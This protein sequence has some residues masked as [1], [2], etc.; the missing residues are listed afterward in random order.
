VHPAFDKKHNAVCLCARMNTNGGYGNFSV[1]GLP[2]TSNLFTLNSQN[3]NDPFVNVNKSGAANLLLG[4]NEL[5]EVSV[6]ANGYSAQYGQLAG[7]NVNYVTKSGTNALHGNAKYYWDGRILNANDFFNNA[8][9]V[10]RQFVNANQWAA[11]MGGPIKRDKTFF[12]VNNE[13][14]RVVLPTATSP[15]RL[16]SLPFQSATLMNLAST[17]MGAEIPFY[18]Q[19]FK[20]FNSATSASRASAI[21]MG[22]GDLAGPGCGDLSILAPG[23]PCVVGYLASPNAFAHEWQ[24]AMR[25]DQT[26]G[27]NDR[28]YGRFQTDRGVAPTYTDPINPIFSAISSQPEDQGQLAWTHTFGP[29]GKSAYRLGALFQRT[30]WAGQ[31]RCRQRI[32]SV[33]FRHERRLAFELKRYRDIYS[34]RPRVHTVSN[35]R[36]PF[37]YGRQTHSESGAEL[38]PRS[39]KR[40]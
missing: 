20:A 30:V 26:I 17:G 35:R 37:V 21:P 14:L 12:F 22:P 2:G 25:I 33:L 3:D 16:P 32:A 31:S 1:F 4:A 7:A 23:V 34:A 11:S 39:G 5:A 18:R 19:L 13:G 29:R 38:P 6:T 15:V 40:L 10:P 8:N 27:G 24:L 9:G 28:L 36:R